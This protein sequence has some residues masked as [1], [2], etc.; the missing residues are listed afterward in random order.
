MSGP[1]LQPP[2]PDWPPKRSAPQITGHIRMTRANCN[3]S[4]LI[5]P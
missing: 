3:A 1:Q 4:V 2:E 5:F